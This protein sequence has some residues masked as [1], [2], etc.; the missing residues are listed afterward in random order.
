MI[1]YFL[2]RYHLLGFAIWDRT[3]IRRSPYGGI[4]NLFGMK[5]MDRL[6]SLPLTHIPRPLHTPR[7]IIPICR[8]ERKKVRGD[9]AKPEI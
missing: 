6:E 1:G 9:V 4:D 2:R 3:F 5:A 7:E 8:Y